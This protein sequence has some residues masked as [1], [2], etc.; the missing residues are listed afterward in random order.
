MVRHEVH[1]QTFRGT[2]NPGHSTGCCCGGPGPGLLSG[3]FCVGRE[4]EM[5]SWTTQAAFFFLKGL[6]ENAFAAWEVRAL[7]FW[8]VPPSQTVSVYFLSLLVSFSG[9]NYDK[10]LPPIQVASLRAERIAKEKKVW[11]RGR[12]DGA[13]VAGMVGSSPRLLSS[14]AGPGRSAEGTTAT[15]GPAPT[16]PT[17]A[18][19]PATPAAA[20][21]SA[22][23]PG[24]GQPAARGA[25]SRPTAGPGA[26][27]GTARA[28]PAEGAPGDHNGG[29]RRSA[30]EKAP[31]PGVGACGDVGQDRLFRCKHVFLRV[32]R[33]PRL[34]L[35]V[36]SVQRGAL[37]HALPAPCSCWPGWWWFGR[38]PWHISLQTW[39]CSCRC[40]SLPSKLVHHVL[41]RAC[42]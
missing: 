16:A 39:Y 3:R 15:C 1:P 4:W 29:Q 22:P 38:C 36:V 5:W 14:S 31:L 42:A 27:P 19:A 41:A 20:P 25:A 40:A 9:I 26:A 18:A 33:G 30:G 12:L 32:S 8:S 35:A 37:T 10:P 23:T 7:G 11:V 13:G 17:A 6:Y 24:G 2:C 28:A 34:S 21:T